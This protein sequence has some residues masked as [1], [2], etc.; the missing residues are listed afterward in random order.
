MAGYGAT[1]AP[2]MGLL[3]QLSEQ[4]LRM[5]QRLFCVIQLRNVFKLKKIFLSLPHV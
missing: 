5:G 2:C 3:L 4:Q 1:D